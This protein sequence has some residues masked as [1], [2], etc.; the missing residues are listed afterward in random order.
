MRRPVPSSRICNRASPCRTDTPSPWRVGA[1]R[2]GS[3]SSSPQRPR[4]RCRGSSCIC[5]GGMSATCRPRTPAAITA[6]CSALC[7]PTPPAQRHTYTPSPQT[8]PHLRRRPRRTSTRC[9][10]SL[11]TVAPRS[12][13][14]SW[15]S[16]PTPTLPRSFPKPRRWANQTTGSAS[17][18]PHPATRC[19]HELRARCRCSMAHAGPSCWSQGH[20]NARP[21]A[22]CSTTRIPR[23]PAPTIV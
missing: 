10:G 17:W 22:P 11:R 16:A 6:W 2:S 19:L 8:A 4:A 3:M 14:S 9:A 13:P 5:S 20:T 12:T 7:S 15:A 21:S 23:A 1:P 18:R